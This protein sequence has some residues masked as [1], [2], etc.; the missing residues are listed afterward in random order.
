MDSPWRPRGIKYTLNEVLI[1]V[2]EYI[3][4]ILDKNGNYIRYDVTGEV[5]VTSFLSGM[6]DLTMIMHIPQPFAAYSLHP[7]AMGRRKRFEEENM[8]CFVP[9]DGQFVALK[10]TI[11]EISPPLPL[12][13]VPSL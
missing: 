5:M 2:I 6:P 9:P 12:R 4:C 3:N 1:D 7:S 8:I 10:Y 13:V 11:D